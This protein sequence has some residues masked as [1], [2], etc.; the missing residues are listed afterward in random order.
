MALKAIISNQTIR[1]D[2]HQWGNKEQKNWDDKS[3][4]IHIDK[5]TNT[6]V[7][8]KR[9][10][11]Q[12]RIPI[13]S[14]RPIKITN[15]NE[16]LEAVPKNLDKEIRKALGNKD[17]REAFISDILKTLKDFPSLLDNERRASDILNRLSKHFGIEWTGETIATY[18][19]DILQYYAQLYTDQ[20]GLKYFLT[21][22]RKKIE[23]GQNNGYARYFKRLPRNNNR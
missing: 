21:V 1:I 20:N 9:Q 2:D 19:K 8:G 14:D 12:I 5:F 16:Q 22:D 3:K 11:L 17:V 23:I 10:Q 13:N 4:D 6:K 15:K 7:E 18:T